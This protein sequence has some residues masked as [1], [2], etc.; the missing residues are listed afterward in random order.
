MTQYGAIEA[1]GTKFVCAVGAGPDQ[2][3]DTVRID[4]TT[5]DHTLSEVIEFFRHHQTTT[6][7][8]ALGIGSF[9]PIDLDR[10]SSTYGH[11]TSTPKSGWAQT[12]LAGLLGKRLDIPV[13]FDTDVNAAALGEHRWGAAQDVDSFI[14]L[15]IGT[16]IGGGAMIGGHLI[17]GLLHPEMGHILVPPDARDTDFGGVCPFHGTCLEGLASGPAIEQRWG[18]P[19]HE[20]D[21]SHPAWELQA[22]YLA[23]GLWTLTCA[24]SPQRL[25]LGGGVMEQAHILPMVRSDL[26]KVSAGYLQADELDGEITKFVVSP[27][28]G[29]RAGICGALA[30]ADLA[31]HQDS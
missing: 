10:N 30:L 12:D 19:A 24:L 8:A 23:R 4:T 25:I 26:Q 31:Y 7:L 17:H 18:Q 2:I 28:L 27:G 14:Y 29:D 13:G 9:G 6:T 20:L 3:V 1:G 11:I 21:A 16:G 22:H 15:T 5:P